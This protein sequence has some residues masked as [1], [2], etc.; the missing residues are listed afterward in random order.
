VL[1]VGDGV[2]SAESFH[3]FGFQATKRPLL[4]ENSTTAGYVEIRKAVSVV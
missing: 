2:Y 4:Q 3:E 1:E